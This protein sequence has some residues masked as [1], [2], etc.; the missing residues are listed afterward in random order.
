MREK[1]PAGHE[2][3]SASGKRWG[4]VKGRAASPRPP[5]HFSR[6]QGCSPR[7]PH[8]GG[9]GEKSGRSRRERPTCPTRDSPR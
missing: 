1:L 8:F 6:G 9:R 5:T 2:R 7:M 4:Q 3:I